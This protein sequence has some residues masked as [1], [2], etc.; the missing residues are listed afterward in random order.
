MSVKSALSN[1]GTYALGLVIMLAF[2][3]L[4]V[5]FIVGGVWVGE[6]VLPWLMLLS[7]LV[8]A[9]NIIIIVPLALI[10]PTRPWAGLGFFFSSYIFGLTGWF[11]GLLL[12][13][14]LWGGI[15]V[16]IGLLILGIG[17]VPIVM[18]ATLFNGMWLE[19]G[20]LF[21][22]IILAF[23]LRILGLTLTENA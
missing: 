15:A 21:L 12:T 7:V 1:I 23:G 9:L 2:L 20:L 14:V 13:W 5:L 4:P 10:P 16:I 6:K 18:L 11:M 17:V 8:L 19:L 3:A 22:A